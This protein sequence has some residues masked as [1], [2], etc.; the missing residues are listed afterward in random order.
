MKIALFFGSFNPV[1]NGHTGLGRYIVEN[2][3]VDEVWFIVSPR[4]PLKNQKELIDEHYRFEMLQLAI[5]DEPLFRAS[6]VEFG[7]PVPSYSIET[8]QL[9]SSKFPEDHFVLMIGSDNA[10]VFDQWKNFEQI[11]TDYE[12]FV[13]PRNG[14]NFEPVSQKFH[15]MKLIN[16]PFFNISSTQIRDAILNKKDLS[17]WIHPS[18]YQYIK[19]N[20]LYK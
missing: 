7:M 11:L 3:L 12:V 2:K 17:N 10:L 16:T 9:L 8:L 13:Y 14:Y 4:N 5:Q 18:V 6:D 19:D 1:H 20:N 15:Q